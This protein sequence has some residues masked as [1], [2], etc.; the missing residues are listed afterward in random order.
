MTAI[1]RA[2]LWSLLG[3]SAELWA[4]KDGVEVEAD[5]WS[6][7]SGANSVDFNVAVCH[8]SGSVAAGRDAILAGGAP[9]LVVLADRALGEAQVLVESSWVCVGA[10]PIM[11]IELEAAGAPE[12]PSPASAERRLDARDLAAAQALIASSFDIPSELGAVALPARALDDPRAAVWG[13]FD[14]TGT[15]F[16]T[17]TLVR[18]EQ[19]VVVLFMATAEAARGVGR[20][21]RLLTTAL[22]GSAAG[23]AEVAV[24]YSSPMAIGFYR[25]YGFN[26]VE[27]WQT[28]S[29]PRWVL[30]RA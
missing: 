25:H 30:G 9:G 1:D 4:G 17:V 27:A 20:S 14:D 7:L 10:A 12:S 6:A 28:W 26:E 24:L 21:A 18:V 2:H 3:R 22:A 13:S 29:R 16:S 8:G 5:W 23:G 15:L 19:F 11:S